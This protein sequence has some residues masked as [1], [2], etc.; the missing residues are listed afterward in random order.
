M[1]IA[2]HLLY[3]A[4]A[5]LHGIVDRRLHGYAGPAEKILIGQAD[6]HMIDLFKHR[7]AHGPALSSLC[8][9]FVP[10]EL[11]LGPTGSA[12]DQAQQCVRDCGGHAR[13]APMGTTW[14]FSSEGVSQYLAQACISCRRS[15]SAVPRR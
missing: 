3:Q 11:D 7:R 10:V 1:G 12:S 4:P 5:L 14:P 15:S 6:Q 2:A 8:D 9:N 13:A